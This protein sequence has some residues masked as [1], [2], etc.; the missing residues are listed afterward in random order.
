[1]KRDQT[2][3]ERLIPMLVEGI[4]AH[5]YLEIGTD[6]NQ[7]IGKVVAPVRIG[8]DP[9]AVPLDGCLM[10]NQTCE[11]FVL[12]NAIR[13][14]PFDFVFI[15][16]DHKAAQVRSDFMNIWPYVAEDGLVALHDTNPEHVSDAQ[17]GFCDD[18][19]KFVVYLNGG[20]FEACTLPYHPG[21]TL[22]RKRVAWG[23]KP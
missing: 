1:M 5:T 17:P 12:E 13:H 7:T 18:A 14:A 20:G 8:M 19:W 2:F 10:F 4:G 15:D 6:Q 16:A 3:H 21:I 9:K 22:V 11:E 23:P